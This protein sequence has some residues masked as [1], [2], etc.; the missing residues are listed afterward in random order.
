[1]NLDPSHLLQGLGTTALVLF[2]IYRRFRRLFGRQEFRPKSM[3][4]RIVL[5]SVIS[6]FLLIPSFFAT[7]LAIAAIAGAAVGVG[8]GL[9]GAR[10]TRFE[11]MDG[12]LFYIPHTYAGMVVSALFIG[13]LAYKIVSGGLSPRVATMDAT[14]GVSDFSNMLH[15][16]TYIAFFALAGYY[17][18]YYSYV[19][20]E[21]KHLKPKDWEGA[22]LRS[23]IK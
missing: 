21:S 12:K 18:Y 15:P 7:K 22:S 1:M 8:L 10:H 14:P 11:K 9:W 19:L 5:L 17:V 16:L 4:F 13:R 3:I 6:A 23:D 2:I 20:Y